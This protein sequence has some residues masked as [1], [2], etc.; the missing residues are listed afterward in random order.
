M[1]TAGVAFTPETFQCPHCGGS[2]LLGV[3]KCDYCGQVVI[4]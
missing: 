3:D 2:L 4:T 1:R